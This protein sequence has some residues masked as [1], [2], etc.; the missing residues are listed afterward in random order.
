MSFHPKVINFFLILFHF[1]SFYR[2]Y[3]N[4][5]YNIVNMNEKNSKKVM[6]KGKITNPDEL[7]QEKADKV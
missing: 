7:A 4:L 6:S 2:N 1:I 3:I 5:I